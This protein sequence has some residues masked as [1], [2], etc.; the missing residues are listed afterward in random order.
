MFHCEENM[1]LRDW[2]KN[3]LFKKKYFPLFIGVLV[4]AKQHLLAFPT[5]HSENIL[6]GDFRASD[7]LDVWTSS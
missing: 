3:L 6:N 7:H 2:I 1:G 4:V 5:D